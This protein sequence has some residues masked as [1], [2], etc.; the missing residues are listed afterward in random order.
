MEHD[1]ASKIGSVTSSWRG[2]DGSLRVSGVVNDA[3]AIKSVR[4]GSTRG[5]SLGTSVITDEE[6]TRL[7]VKHDELSVCERPAR[8]GCYIDSVNG[9]SVR[10]VACFSSK[11]K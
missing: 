7:M 8:A 11:G 9:K 5:L 1:H 10:Q 6:G 2:P 3:N 4:D